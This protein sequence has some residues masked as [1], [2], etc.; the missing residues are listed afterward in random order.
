M[1]M[2]GSPV[3]LG[4]TVIQACTLVR[5]Q[6]PPELWEAR[7]AE[8]G[9]SGCE[10]AEMRMGSLDG[11]RGGSGRPGTSRYAEGK[12]LVWALP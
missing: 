6:R 3:R 1:V 2:G 10:E 12:A 11:L 9:S 5:R 8:G 7:E 4:G